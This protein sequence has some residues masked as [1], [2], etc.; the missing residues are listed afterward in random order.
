ME[1][2]LKFYLSL[3][4][5]FSL[6]ACQPQQQYYQKE[7]S[8]AEQLELADKLLSGLGYRNYYQGSVG[9]QMLLDEAGKHNNKHAEIWRERGIPYLKR[10]IA[11]GY[12]P[13]YEKCVRY[14]SIGWQGWRGYCTLYFY[15]DY[16]RALKDF[17]E[18]DV[19]TP[20]FLDYPQATS[21]DYMRGV[22][23][24]GMEQPI[25]ALEYLTR[26]LETE[27]QQIGYQYIYPAAFIQTG[28][29][30]KKTGQIEAAQ[31]IFELGIQ[32]NT[33]NA[34]LEY[35]LAKLL[36]EKGEILA[37]KKWNQKAKTSFLEGFF[38]SRPYVEEFY[39]VYLPDIEELEK[40][41]E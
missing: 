9:E 25:K 36:F 20:N 38:N 34:D 2:L 11:W 5:L 12:Y 14:D 37:A 27:S 35:Q 32:H 40:L 16:E 1:K 29:A 15:R 23:Y 6:V 4:I 39:Q 8:E 10:G 19:L 21:I 33:Q 18:L 13:N 28:I 22:C 31:K 3:M 7:F 26:H 17:D 24:L 41:M 30:Y